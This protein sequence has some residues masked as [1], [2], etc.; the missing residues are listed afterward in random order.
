VRDEL[1]ATISIRLR[2]ASPDSDRNIHDLIALIA[3]RHHI[4]V[5]TPVAPRRGRRIGER[6]GCQRPAGLGLRD[7][8]LAASCVAHHD[9]VGVGTYVRPTPDLNHHGRHRSSMLDIAES[10]IPHH[11]PPL[12]RRPYAYPLPG[13]YTH[14]IPCGTHQL[15]INPV[16]AGASHR[17]PRYCT[18]AHCQARRRNAQTPP[19]GYP[20]GVR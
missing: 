20:H 17:H 14:E 11:K 1:A 13:A 7:Q 8:G 18:P 3:G 15:V 12:G 16:I 2:D 6:S 4:R 9:E 10:Y 5:S 19:S